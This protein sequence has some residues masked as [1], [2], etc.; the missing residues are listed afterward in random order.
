METKY[1]PETIHA[2]NDPCEL[3]SSGVTSEV[4]TYCSAVYY[5]QSFRQLP[6]RS[7]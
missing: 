2:Y 6:P 1:T 3:R 4:L 7:F 5:I